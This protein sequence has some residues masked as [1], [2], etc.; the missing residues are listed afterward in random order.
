MKIS[1][2]TSRT[3]GWIYR[4][5]K[6]PKGGGQEPIGFFTCLAVEASI[7][8]LSFE[9]KG[10]RGNLRKSHTGFLRKETKK[11]AI[12]RIPRSEFPKRSS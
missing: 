7:R 2:N 3:L 8:S 6:E 5:G 12:P 9:L 10:K 1:S 4:Q 11:S